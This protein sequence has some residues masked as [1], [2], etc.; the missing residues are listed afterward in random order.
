[1]TLIDMSKNTMMMWA[2]P[3]LMALLLAMAVGCGGDDAPPPPAPPPT[4]PPVRVD[5]TEV[6][7]EAPPSA[8]MEA[9]RKELEALK[10]AI[11]ESE[12]ESAGSGGTATGS[13]NF[14]APTLTPAAT[15]T[16]YPTATPYPTTRPNPTATATQQSLTLLPTPTPRP[17]A[18]ATPRPRPTAT[19]T[20]V[21]VPTPH[22][23]RKVLEALY[24]AT[25]GDNWASNCN[26][27]SDKPLDQWCGVETDGTGR[28]IKLNLSVNRLRG[29]IPS[30]LGDLTYLGELYLHSNNLGGTI[31]PELGNLTKL[32]VLRLYNNGLS[33]SIPPEFGNLVNLVSLE[34]ESNK[35]S[36]TIPP[37]LDNLT[38]LSHI[39][40]YG[41]PLIGPIPPG[42]DDLARS[43]NV[44][45]SLMDDREALEALYNA[46]GGDNW[47]SNCNWKSDKP[48]DQWCGVETNRTGRVIKL[49]LS[50][51]RLRGSIP[52][53]L[54][55]LTYLGELYLHSNNLGGT[56]PPELGNLTKLTVLRLYNNGLSGSIPPEFGNLVNLVSLE[57]ESN[58]LSGTIPPELDN[59]T[60]L[61]HISLYGN[62]LIGPI[63]PGIDDLARS[64]NVR[65]SLMDDREALEALYNATGGDNWAS[66]CNWKSDKPLDQWCG[67][68]TNRT[69]RVIKLNLSGN[70]LRGSI[71]S[72]LGDLTYLVALYLVNNYI[73]SYTVPL[74]LAGLI[75]CEL[76]NNEAGLL[77]C[78]Q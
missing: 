58:K 56:I 39:S 31:P 60:L 43:N 25:G 57:L 53:E 68:E 8:E 44:R 73:E 33:G 62:P 61:S 66:N 30:E 10:V 78:K 67:V 4:A 36:G 59:L 32:T 9:L 28:V 22:S 35:L 18:T 75:A 17:P 21:P 48:L 27:K 12:S 76:T 51:N 6:P 5:E 40:L 54:G 14:P 15:L 72:E 71:P 19:N 37:E 45:I 52:S 70:R 16:P 46:T 7:A 42:I 74:G 77:I 2:A 34:L 63:P 3:V 29:S 23:D 24:N 47:A 20:P 13:P 49:N 26:W 65:I 11:Q 69:G 1:M 55:D 50:V 38:L 64:N 41:N